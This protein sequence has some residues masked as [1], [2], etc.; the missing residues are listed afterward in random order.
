MGRASRRKQQRRTATTKVVAVTPAR[1]VSKI[2]AGRGAHVPLTPDWDIDDLAAPLRNCAGNMIP[3][4][5]AIGLL[6]GV[7][8]SQPAN[9]CAY[10]S[11]QLAGAL[12]HLGY[13]AELVAACVNVRSLDG[14]STDVGVWERPPRIRRNGTTDGHVV[15]WTS[16]FGR[17]IDLTVGQDPQLQRAARRN[18]AL[19][20]PVVGELN[21]L[22]AFGEGPTPIVPRP[23]FAFAYM[24][25]PQYTPVMAPLWE[26][27]AVTEQ[28]DFGALAFAYDTLELVRATESRRRRPTGT[29][30]RAL[31]DGK[32]QL[33]PLPTVA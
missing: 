10:A 20:A 14:L 6:S 11:Y 24:L 3:M 21:E 30:M 19:A 16:S 4:W 2:P 5:A 18:P 8:R 27:S 9:S 1:A 7:S 31:L 32:A 13:D 33:P 26:N 29:R 28:L 22:V 25:L 15:V 12:G 23:P 17:L